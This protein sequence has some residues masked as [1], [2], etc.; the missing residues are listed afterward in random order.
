MLAFLILYCYLGEV[1]T[2]IV[3]NSIL[4]AFGIKESVTKCVET[5]GFS[6]IDEILKVSFEKFPFAY[7]SAFVMTQSA[8]KFCKSLGCVQK[9][10]QTL[11][12][13]PW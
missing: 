8:I 6:S 9:L 10:M 12:A 1:V 2:S 11:E 3:S 7:T 5:Y 4:M 13:R